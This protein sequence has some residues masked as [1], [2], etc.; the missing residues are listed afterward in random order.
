M[1]TVAADTHAA[2]WFLE[3]DKR[4]T[5][6]ASEA[7]DGA[8]HILLPSI[9]LVEITYLVEKGR[10]HAAMLPRILG[11]LNNPVTTLELAALDL[12]VVRALQD[13]SR[14]DVPDMPDRVIAATAFHHCVPLVTC[15][16]K[17]RS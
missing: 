5:R 4:L 8:Q 6:A 17:I 2:I 11:E 13:V 14:L 3:N 16:A 1:N 10:L 15:D 9:C 12:G 7:L